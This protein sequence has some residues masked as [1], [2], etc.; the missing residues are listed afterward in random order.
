V[1]HGFGD[2]LNLCENVFFSIQYCGGGLTLRGSSFCKRRLPVSY[3][4]NNVD[5]KE[6]VSGKESE[7][8]CDL[9]NKKTLKCVRAS[10]KDSNNS[11]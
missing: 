6:H 9:K 2:F 4:I 11:L 5:K 3:E 10:P 8:K 7:R 1:G